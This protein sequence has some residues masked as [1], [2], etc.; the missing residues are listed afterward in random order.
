VFTRSCKLEDPS[1]CASLAILLAGLS[2]ATPDAPRDP[3]QALALAKK[4]CDRGSGLACDA[5]G[6]MLSASHDPRAPDYWRLA[7]DMG[8][9]D[10]DGYQ[11]CTHLAQ[12]K[13]D[14]DGV[15]ADV[16]GAIAIASRACDAGMPAACNLVGWTYWD[17][18]HVPRDA[19]KA[20]TFFRRACDRGDEYGCTNL[21]VRYLRG[22]GVEPDRGKALRLFQWAC[23]RGFAK[24]CDD[25]KIFGAEPSGAS[26]PPSSLNPPQ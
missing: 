9:R 16:E 11:G 8:P 13:L 26:T 21:G 10:R 17:E 22:E 5:Y 7:C 18:K 1:G 23:D 4:W 12:A 6:R 24:A 2:G 14:G 20:V 3:D 19:G 25:V 15:A